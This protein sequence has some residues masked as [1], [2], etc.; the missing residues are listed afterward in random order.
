MLEAM[1]YRCGIVAANVG[2]IPYMITDRETGL[3]AAPKDE[4]ALRNALVCILRDE[5]LCSRLGNAAR[6]KA[7]REFAIEANIEQLVKIYQGVLAQ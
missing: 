6:D 3:L 4:T 2:G 1:A 7:K 5:E